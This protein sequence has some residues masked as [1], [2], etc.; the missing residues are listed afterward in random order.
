MHSSISTI[1]IGISSIIIGIAVNYPLHFI[2]HTHHEPNAGRTLKDIAV[3]LTIGNIST[4]GAFLA[5]VPLKGIALRDLGLFASLLLLG[6]ILFVLIF[7][8]HMVRAGG[9]GSHHGNLLHALRLSGPRRSP[10][11]WAL[12]AC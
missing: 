3:P 10:G 6:T 7:L 4:I 8:P 1:V 2:S 12:P 11:R 9:R 5:L